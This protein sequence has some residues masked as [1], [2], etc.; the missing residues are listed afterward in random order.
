M[1]DLATG[2]NPAFRVSRIEVDRGGV[3]Y[4]VDTLTTLAAEDPR[5]ELFFLLGADSLL[6]LPNWREPERILELAS[7]VVVSRPGVPEFD[8]NALAGLTSAER[9]SEFRRNQVEMSQVGLS[10]SEI[11]HRVA[12]GRSI[13]YRTPRAV[14]TYIQTHG[15]YRKPA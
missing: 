6:D 13:R 14:E 11:R 15:L 5:R 9:L 10:S 12:A 7:P 1:L 4:T 3:S 2:G 8:F